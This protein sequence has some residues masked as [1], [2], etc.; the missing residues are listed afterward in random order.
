MKPATAPPTTAPPTTR[1][2][3]PASPLE[4][5][6]LQACLEEAR[7][8]QAQAAPYMQQAQAAVKRGVDLVLEAQGYTLTGSEVATIGSQDGKP[9]LVIQ[10]EA[11]A[12]AVEPEGIPFDKLRAAREDEAEIEREWA[13]LDAETKAKEAALAPEREARILADGELEAAVAALIKSDD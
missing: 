4:A 9:V 1:T 8:R 6:A 10:G 7:A 13:E 2:L 11:E 12:K 5:F 3:A